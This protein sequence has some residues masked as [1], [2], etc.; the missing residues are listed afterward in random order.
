MLK[1]REFPKDDP[2][3]A[4]H[5]KYAVLLQSKCY[6]LG[7][8]PCSSAPSL[9]RSRRSVRG[10]ESQWECCLFLKWEVLHKAQDTENG[11]IRSS[12][13]AI[14]KATAAAR[15]CLNDR[16]AKAMRQTAFRNNARQ[17]KRKNGHVNGGK[18]GWKQDALNFLLLYTKWI[19]S[20]Q[21]LSMPWQDSKCHDS[22]SATGIQS[23]QYNLIQS[24]K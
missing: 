6:Y 5:A 10:W 1:K 22:L 16:S 7:T 9:L 12:N 23:E 21:P 14:Y 15:L 20:D 13:R 24:K 17:K 8:V 4:R 18:R 3:L 2:N 11:C 19:N